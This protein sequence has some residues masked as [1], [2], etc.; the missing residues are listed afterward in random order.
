[1]GVADSSHRT[2]HPLKRRK[3][4]HNTTATFRPVADATPLKD[5][6]GDRCTSCR[7]A[8]PAS[9]QNQLL[10][11]ARCLSST[12]TI[13][14]RICNG[15]PPSTTVPPTPTLTDT[16]SLPDTPLESPFRTPDSLPRR[17][18]LSQSTNMVVD[19][20]VA[21]SVAGRRRKVRDEDFAEGA[22]SAEGSGDGDGEDM[23]TPGCGR[24]ICQNC[25]FET[26]SRDITTCYDC[27][28]RPHTP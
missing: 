21:S 19:V 6:K 14:S 5:L 15:C 25:S 3:T 10:Q 18:A 28:G 8:F 12:C 23:A 2:I 26:P 17:P 16:P 24:T 13:C 22:R 9:K 20:G 27:G 7:R 11:C 4:S 1:M